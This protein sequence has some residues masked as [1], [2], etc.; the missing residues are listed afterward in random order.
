MRC[1]ILRIFDGVM[2]MDG[3]PTF[4]VVDAGKNRISPAIP[5]LILNY[6]ISASIGVIICQNIITSFYWRHLNNN[7]FY[8]GMVPEVIKGSQLGA[9]CP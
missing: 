4:G 7:N 9:F 2:M 1:F 6:D 5:I 8:D 3:H